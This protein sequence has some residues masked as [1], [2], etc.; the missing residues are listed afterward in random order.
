MSTS[1]PTLVETETLLKSA[2]HDLRACSEL[3]QKTNVRISELLI[4]IGELE[5][6][7]SIV[8]LDKICTCN[9]ESWW[10]G[11]TAECAVTKRHTPTP[12]VLGLQRFNQTGQYKPFLRAAKYDELRDDDKFLYNSDA[13]MLCTHCGM[14]REYALTN[15]SLSCAPPFAD[16]VHLFDGNHPAMQ[17]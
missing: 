4:T 2:M 15:L 14:S 5:R 6:R 9:A 16:R 1:D 11:H 10:R 13:N 3:M 12:A 7:R 8:Q 17:P